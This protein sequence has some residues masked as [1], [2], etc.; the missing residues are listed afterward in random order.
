VANDS[1]QLIKLQLYAGLVLDSYTVYSKQELL[2]ETVDLADQFC[3][4][5]N[6][7]C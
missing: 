5:K 7:V 1:W 2:V 4:K 3:P 6:G